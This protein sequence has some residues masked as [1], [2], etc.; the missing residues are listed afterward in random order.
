MYVFFSLWQVLASENIFYHYPVWSLVH[1]KSLFSVLQ[2][3]KFYDCFI[4]V[5]EEK[6]PCK[7]F[8]LY[9]VQASSRL[10]SKGYL[11]GQMSWATT[12]K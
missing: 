11:F 1:L 6:I 7:I 8:A 5:T 4:L 2:T 10:I 9:W 3:H 12:G